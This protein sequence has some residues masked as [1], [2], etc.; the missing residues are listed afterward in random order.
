MILA[1]SPFLLIG[2]CSMKY[3]T[4][5]IVASIFSVAC[6]SPSAQVQGSSCAGERAKAAC[7][8]PTLAKASKRVIDRTKQTVK[9]VVSVLK[10]DCSGN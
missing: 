5:L 10:R 6:L 2:V 1:F 3:L 9:N 8:G 7:S 4:C